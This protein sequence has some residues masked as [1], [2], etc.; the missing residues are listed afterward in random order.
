MIMESASADPG[1]AGRQVR[2]RAITPADRRTLAGFDRDSAAEP[3][4]RI[5]G[6]RHWAAHRASSGDDLQFAIETLRGRILVGSL[7]VI[8]AGPH[9]DRFS[10]GIGIGPRYRRCG[11]AADAIT[12]LLAIM[13]GRGYRGCEVTV[14]GGNLASLAL[15]GSLGFREQ[16]RLRD[17]ELLRGQV[18]YPVTMHLTAAEFARR[19][20]DSRG[21]G[22]P[23]SARRGRHWRNRR[24][25]HWDPGVRIGSR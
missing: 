23:E 13:F 3:A 8:P 22:A 10:Y 24:G 14:Y 21:A 2:L 9:A 16:A 19:H 7:H 4:T 5:G 18:K 12:V 11:Y 25:R 15:H 17:A 1:P 6:Y 20:A